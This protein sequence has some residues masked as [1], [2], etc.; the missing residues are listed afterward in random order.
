[1]SSGPRCGIAVFALACLACSADRI[2]TEDAV[3]TF[4]ASAWAGNTLVL[5]STAFHGADTL[6]TV[7]AGVDTLPL[8]SF[9]AESVLVKLPDTS[10]W[11]TLYLH[12]AGGAVIPI[13]EV[14]LYGFAGAGQ[15]PPT[16]GPIRVWPG[17]G[18]PLTLAIQGGRLVRLDLPSTTASLVLPDTGL[19]RYPCLFSGPMASAV[20]PRLVVVTR[21]V[22]SSCGPLV[23]VPLVP[24][25]IAPDTGPVPWGYSAVHLGRGRWLVASHHWMAFVTGSPAAG[26]VTGPAIDVPAPPGFAV[27]PRGDR[28]V[29]VLS[30]DYLPDRT[31]VFD[32][33]GPGIAYSL[34]GLDIV[35][36]AVFSP[37]GDTLLVTG[38][39]LEGNEVQALD[40]TTGRVLVRAALRPRNADLALDPTHP[41]VYAAGTVDEEPVVQVLDRATLQPVATLRVPLGA[42]TGASLPQPLSSSDNVLV[43]DAAERRLYFVLNWWSGTFAMRF[44]LMP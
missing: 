27:S 40:A 24:G 7:T 29:P 30:S 9:G 3:V 6:P 26:F 4:D 17:A 36:N 25:T 39:R 41:F 23:A 13:G 44:D 22:G 18:E 15:G 34:Q 14:R 43:M 11:I 21:M 10:G 19:S 16:D 1:M 37:G 8:R 31:P 2:T 20:D 5:R 32:P 33:A 38:S 42:L 12:R 28:V 35:A